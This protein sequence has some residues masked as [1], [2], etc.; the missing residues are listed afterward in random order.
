MEGS[1][2]GGGKGGRRGE[3]RRGGRDVDLDTQTQNVDDPL[4]K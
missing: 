2:F 3:R 1:R 4:L